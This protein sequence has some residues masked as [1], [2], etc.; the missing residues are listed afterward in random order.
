MPRSGAG[1]D[2]HGPAVAN[3]KLMREES[4]AGIP[5][6]SKVC[7]PFSSTEIHILNPA[8]ALV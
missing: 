4:K 3:L 5:L 2:R 1:P 6:V 7:V 8:R